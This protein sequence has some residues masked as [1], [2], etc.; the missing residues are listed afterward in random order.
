MGEK[1]PK[2][3]H[4][5]SLVNVLAF[6]SSTAERRVLRLPMGRVKRAKRD[7]RGD[8]SIAKPIGTIQYNAVPYGTG[9]IKYAC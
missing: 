2:N 9:N 6:L 5:A 3:T 1:D 7:E 8:V 4:R